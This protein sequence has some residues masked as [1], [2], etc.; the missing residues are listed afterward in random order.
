MANERPQEMELVA[1]DPVKPVDLSAPETG[2]RPN[3]IRAAIYARI[4]S[5]KK[6]NYSINEQIACCRKYIDQRGWATHYLFFDEVFRWCHHFRP[7]FQSMLERA[8]W[9]DWSAGE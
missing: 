1:N 9:Q 3:I 2:T 5:F 7:K 4:S 6:T 8:K